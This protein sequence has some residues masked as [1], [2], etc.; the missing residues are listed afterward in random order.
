MD[1]GLR[2][3]LCALRFLDVVDVRVSGATTGSSVGVAVGVAMVLL[4]CMAMLEIGG[5]VSTL[6][7]VVWSAWLLVLVG[8]EL[9]VPTV[10]PS[11]GVLL[12][13]KRSCVCLVDLTR[14]DK[15]VVLSIVI[16]VAAAGMGA[17]GVSAADVLVC[18]RSRCVLRRD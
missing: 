2:C 3:I 13:A 4:C 12:G 16:L 14:L 15:G 1:T 9:Y 7:G 17:V 6:V 18:A 5:E 10:L 11:S 8:L